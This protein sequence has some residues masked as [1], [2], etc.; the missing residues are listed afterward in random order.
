MCQS[1]ISLV[2]SYGYLIIS[3]LL[4]IIYLI[5]YKMYK[6]KHKRW[7]KAFVIA[8]VILVL[9]LSVKGIIYLTNN[10]KLN[11]YMNNVCKCD[12][13]PVSSNN[14]DKTTSSSSSTSTSATSSTSSTATTTTKESGKVYKKIP[15]PSGEKKVI[16]KSSKGYDI[17]SID[18]VTYIDGYL[19]ANKSYPLPQDFVPK[20]TKSTTNDLS[21]VCNNCIN[22]QAYEALEDMKA[23]A[24]AVGLKLWNQSG[25]RS[26]TVQNTLYNN[27][28]TREKNNGLTYEAA[29]AEAD[30]YSARPGYSE[31]QS[32]E[33]FDLN[34]AGRAF[35]GT[36]EAKW[37]AQNAAKY[38]FI[39]RYPEGKT[40]ETGYIYESWH[41]RYVGEELAN[42]LYNNG[43][44][45]T[46][47]SYFGITSIYAE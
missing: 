5:S 44:W 20:N 33:C 19:I 25:F 28:I 39:I 3:I 30:T 22:T 38:G 21:K 45:I 26:Y 14:D 1:N 36:K 46:M 7:D 12:T 9:M 32:G 23:D 8:F 2:I 4:P 42:K 27:Y 43:D 6:I 40:N 11:C 10:D 31:H 24:A 16:G 18:G 15:E 17:Y 47:E 37:V 29:K 34:N 35:N 41:L 13:T